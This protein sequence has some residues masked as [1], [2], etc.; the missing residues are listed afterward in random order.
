[1]KSTTPTMDDLVTPYCCNV[2]KKYFAGPGTLKIHE[3]IH[4]GEKPSAPPIAETDNL[5]GKE[6][7]FQCKVCDKK[8][9]KFSKLQ[10]HERIHTNENPFSCISTK[11]LLNTDRRTKEIALRCE[12]AYKNRNKKILRR[13]YSIVNR[14]QSGRRTDFV[15][16]RVFLR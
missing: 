7:K 13:T 12:N 3:R 11:A 4:T 1:M 9:P 8:F 14:V 10:A 6:D 5:Q 16:I 2:C 15:N